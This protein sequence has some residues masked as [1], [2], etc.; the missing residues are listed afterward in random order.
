M[1]GGGEVQDRYSGDIGDYV[2]LAILRNLSPGYRLGVA[3]WLFP[4]ETHNTD[5]RHIDYLSKPEKWGAYDP[6][7]FAGLSK[8]VQSGIRRVAALEGTAQLPGAIFMRE[9]IPV[10]VPPRERPL[11]R[12]DWFGRLKRDFVDRDLIFLDPDNGLE[13]SN[14]R[15]TRRKA[16]KSVLLE[17]LRSLRQPNRCLILYHHQTRY[18]GGHYA[19]I[20]YQAD[21]LKSI[22]F[23]VVDVLR[24]NPYSARAFFI[25]DAPDKIRERA[26]QFARNW[27]PRVTWHSM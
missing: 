23:N 10:E 27:D 26:C 5:G 12:Q 3:W 1:V 13:P 19:E 24:A 22:G 4:D 25:L 14:C 6:E 9:P 11:R 21:R 7:L 20:A 15:I 16:G 18:S 17:E 2:K 8:L